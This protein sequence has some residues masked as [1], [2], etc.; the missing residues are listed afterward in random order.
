MRYIAKVQEWV[1]HAN[2]SKLRQREVE[3]VRRGAVESPLHSKAG[4]NFAFANRVLWV[5][6]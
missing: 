3:L 2:V 1:G 5:R 6:V 4:S